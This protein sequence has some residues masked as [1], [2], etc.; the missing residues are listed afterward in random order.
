MRRG[1]ML[2]RCAWKS[3]FIDTWVARI[4]ALLVI[5][6]AQGVAASAADGETAQGGVVRLLWRVPC[7]PNFVMV[8]DILVRLSG[9]ERSQ[10]SN[11]PRGRIKS[12]S[13][14]RRGSL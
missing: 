1:R 13:G 12:A 3:V 2:T 5:S 6:T 11:R 7:A 14:G 8:I 4:V 10:N 9:R